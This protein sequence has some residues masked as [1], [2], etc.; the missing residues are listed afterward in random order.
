MLVSS[1][2]H[3]AWRHISLE[4]SP[5]EPSPPPPSSAYQGIEPDDD[6]IAVTESQMR[7]PVELGESLLGPQETPIP[8][9]AAITFNRIRLVF[10][11]NHM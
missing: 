8:S 7:R 5:T 2:S 6:D 4:D 9:L 11:G 1:D 3:Q 10:V